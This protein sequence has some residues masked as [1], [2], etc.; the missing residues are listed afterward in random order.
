VT[1]VVEYSVSSSLAFS[2]HHRHRLGLPWDRVGRVAGAAACMT[3]V[4]FILRTV[5]LPLAIVASGAAYLVG[6][7]A[8]GAVTKADARALTDRR[9]P[10]GSA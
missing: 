5:P 9:L 4:A 6:G 1:V 10:L 8:L 3:A 7:V 2:I